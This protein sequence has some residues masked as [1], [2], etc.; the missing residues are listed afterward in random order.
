MKASFLGVSE[1][2]NNDLQGLYA[3]YILEAHADTQC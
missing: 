2:G 1:V 3:Q